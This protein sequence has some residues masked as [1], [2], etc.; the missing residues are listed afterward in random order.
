LDLSPFR[1]FAI[2]DWIVDQAVRA[3]PLMPDRATGL[4]RP[5]RSLV[6]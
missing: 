6:G 4:A 1:R 2:G 3:R 5:L